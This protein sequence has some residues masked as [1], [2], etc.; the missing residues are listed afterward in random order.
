[1]IDFDNMSDFDK[2]RPWTQ[3]EI[4]EAKKIYAIAD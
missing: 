2:M 4:A 3:E 1:M